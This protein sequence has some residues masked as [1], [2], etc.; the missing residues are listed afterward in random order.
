VDGRLF[1]V[2]GE[3]MFN[4]GAHELVWKGT[5]QNGRNVSSGLYFAVVKGRE[6]TRRLKITLLK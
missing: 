2:L 3:E 6:E 4:P 1:R 5:D